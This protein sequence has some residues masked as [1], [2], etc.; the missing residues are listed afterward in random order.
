MPYLVLLGIALVS[1]GLPLLFSL[2]RRKVF[3]GAPHGKEYVHGAVFSF[4]AS[5]YAFFIGFSIVTLWSDFNTAKM[6]VNAEANALL[7]VHRLS[8]I[9]E[10]G[11]A[12]RTSVRTYIDS[13]INAEWP[14]MDADGVM[15]QDTA[16]HFAEIWKQYL[17]LKPLDGSDKSLYANLN[18]ALIEASKKRLT[19]SVL[20]GGNLYPLVWVIIGVGFVGIAV[21][22]FVTNAGNHA[23]KTQLEAFIL[24]VVL[25]CVYLIYDIS[26]PFSGY[27]NVTPGA[28]EEVRA[29]IAAH[30]WDLGQ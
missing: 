25:A 21:C 28:F 4:Y 26:T 13:A 22:L 9:L 1:L 2:A 10:Q 12:L 17:L 16:N 23:S 19:R 5:L 14:K 24:F 11:D 3:R 7:I 30:K 15:D 8:H 20:L 18:G 29:T 27:V 6:E